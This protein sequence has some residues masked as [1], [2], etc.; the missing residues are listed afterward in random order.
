MPTIAATF[1]RHDCITLSS[2]GYLD[3]YHSDTDMRL[4]YATSLCDEHSRVQKLMPKDFLVVIGDEL[5][6]EQAIEYEGKGLF[7]IHIDSLGSYLN[8]WRQ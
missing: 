2:S 4:S 5:S 6:D 3:Y 8:T 7:F 1:H